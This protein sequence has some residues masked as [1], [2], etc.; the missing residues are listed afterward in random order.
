MGGFYIHPVLAI[1][2][3]VSVSAIVGLVVLYARWVTRDQYFF[4]YVSY[5]CSALGLIAWLG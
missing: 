1:A 2:L 4:H 3:L 5:E